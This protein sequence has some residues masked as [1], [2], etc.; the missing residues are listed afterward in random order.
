MITTYYLQAATQ[1]AILAALEAAGLAQS[2]PEQTITE[3][4]YEAQEFAD[5][6]DELDAALI[7]L[8]GLEPVQIEHEGAAYYCNGERYMTLETVT[9]PEQTFTTPAYL[10][11]AEG[12]HIV[13]VG[14]ITKNTGTEDAPVWE[15][16]P[17]YHIN[18]HLDERYGDLSDEQRAML[19]IIAAPKNPVSVLA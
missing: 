2:V 18:L 7:A 19:P 13:D 16:L 6:A 4:A 1:A 12:V 11:K 8:Y 5:V 14:I 3:P 10:A 17:G 15:T 9:V